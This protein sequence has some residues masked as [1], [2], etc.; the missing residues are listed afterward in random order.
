[1]LLDN[2]I[3]FITC[4]ND[5]NIYKECLRYIDSIIIPEGYTVEKIAIREANSLT[6]GYNTAM[7]K[8]NAKYKVYL[9]QDTFIIDKNFIYNILEVFQDKKI[10]IIGAA[11]SKYIT[12]NG[13]FWGNTE[14][15]LNL[16]DNTAG[17]MRDT[18][19]KCFSNNITKVEYLNGLIMITQY[20]ILWREDIFDGW[21]FYDISQCVEFKK[22]NYDI[23]IL[24]KEHP[25]VLHDCGVIDI[26]NSEDYYKYKDIFLKE[27][28]KYI[29]PLVSIIIMAC[30]RAEYFK[31]A[32]E[33]ALVQDYINKEIIILDNSI[34]D[35]IEK[36]I[37][38]YLENVYIKYC[39]TSNK[40]SIIENFNKVI[41]LTNGEYICFLMSDDVYSPKKLSTMME[42]FI[43]DIS[44]SLVTS[45]R[46][47]INKFGALSYHKSEDKKIFMQPTFLNEQAIKEY[48]ALTRENFIG[49]IS[50]PIFRKSLLPKEGFGYYKGHKY[51]AISDLV[52]W[53]NLS[54]KGK[55]I[56]LPDKL[57]YF[58][59]YKN[60]DLERKKLKY[61]GNS[62]KNYLVNS[63]YDEL[64]D[65]SIK[66]QV[67]GNAALSN[68]KLLEKLILKDHQDVSKETVNNLVTSILIILKNLSKTYIRDSS[69]AYN[70][71]RYIQLL[72]K[73]Y[74]NSLNYIVSNEIL[75]LC[76]EYENLLDDNKYIDYINSLYNFK[77]NEYKEYKQNELI[78]FNKNNIKYIA[79]YLPQFHSIP[80]NDKWWGKG[81]TE[82]TNVTRAMPLFAGH[83][84]PH[85]PGE[86]GFY[87]LLDKQVLERQIKLA[88]NY[89]VF[90]F[91]FYYYWFNGKRLLEKP[92][93][94]F[95]KNK[96][97]NMPFCLC[98][99]NENWSR[100][101]D[102]S[103][104]AILIEQVHNKENDKKI[105][106]DLISYFKDNRYIRIEN[107]PLLIIYR[108]DIIPNIKE[109]IN[110][111]REICRENEIGEI[112][113]VGAK[114]FNFTNPEDYGFDAAV[115]FPPHRYL[116]SNIE[117]NEFQLHKKNF[118][119]GL[120]DYK[121]LVEKKLYFKH[122]DYKIFK[123]AV[124][125]W[126]NTARKHN[127]ATIFHGSTPGLYGEWLE[128]ISNYTKEKF[129]NDERLVFINAWNEWAEGAH[130]EPDRR[131]GYAYLEKTYEVF[132]KVNKK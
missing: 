67:I 39:R 20:D 102:G 131:Y 29:F 19:N 28:S 61:L 36:V 101:W 17:V 117:I 44:V 127:N 35:S 81:F 26:E 100:R 48:I 11:G 110:Y 69:I 88:Q 82:W 118:T 43:K 62:E 74:D 113:I 103:E 115:E 30:N 7:S 21:H 55:V 116:Q 57:T 84:Q 52:T 90:G 4:V 51:K 92:I 53:I 34:N 85:L 31:L 64:N 124:P 107:K 22:S 119:G 120:F 42:Y 132:K 41:S 45:Y 56:Y 75:D 49:N 70:S 111:W 27:Y 112:Y 38:S 9:H 13:M 14:C 129:T 63:L 37:K 83:Y 97:L 98:W 54:E 89:G 6:S 46:E 72:N 66:S 78:T 128:E 109:T 105:I 130:L 121:Y 47:S 10:G 114:T 1:M 59:I 32:L 77:D 40:V 23:V 125:S 12:P 68:V 24:N 99:A 94:L 96:D 33:S 25:W 87:N 79:F 104:K 71:L 50:T 15:H 123:T 65:N 60:S 108:A 5:E 86:L 126:D 16:H 80:E 106:L 58:R 18:S 91:C 3:C 2:K 93:D 95:I 122:E 76:G 8:S 73:V